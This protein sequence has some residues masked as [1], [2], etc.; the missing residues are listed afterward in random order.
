ML[1]RS[2]LVGIFLAFLARGQL[3]AQQPSSPANGVAPSLRSF[4]SDA[5]LASYLKRIA[6]L[7]AAAQE[8]EDSGWGALCGS[9][10]SVTRR[11]KLQSQTRTSSANAAIRVILSDTAGRKVSGANLDVGDA[12]IRA[13]TDD[14]GHAL[15]V[16]PADK[17]SESHRMSLM[18]RGMSYKFRR[19]YFNVYAGDT[20]DVEISLC[21]YSPVLQEAVSTSGGSGRAQANFAP[22]EQGVDEG[23]D[24]SALG[25]FLLI[26]RRGRLYSFDLGPDSRHGRAMRLIGFMNLYGAAGNTVFRPYYRDDVARKSDCRG[27]L[28][29]L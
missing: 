12:N 21:N 2:A 19:G 4:R 28:R 10:F 14:S 24:V 26:L 15:L 29:Y 1:I 16:I 7:A 6:A 3:F 25:R 11:S 27:R 17:I 5:E 20:L 18:S 9:K 13:T 22:A 23:D 8:R